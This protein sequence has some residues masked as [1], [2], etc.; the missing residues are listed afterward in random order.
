M[1]RKKVKSGMYNNASDVVR[2]ALRIMERE[3]VLGRLRAEV[4]IGLDQLDRGKWE[5]Y[6]DYTMEKLRR[7]AE[8]TSRLGKSIRDVDKS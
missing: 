5:E 4:Q 6:T 2:E 3:E 8:D 1:V 7:G